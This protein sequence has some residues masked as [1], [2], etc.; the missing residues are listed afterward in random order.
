M[1]DKGKP[2]RNAS[3]PSPFTRT[4]HALRCVLSFILWPS[5]S[6][7]TL[8]PRLV[9]TGLTLYTLHNFSSPDGRITIDFAFRDDIL[10]VP[11]FRR[12]TLSMEGVHD[13][14]LKALPANSISYWIRRS[15][16]RA[17][18]D[19]PLQPYALRHEVGTELTDRGVSDQ[20]RNQILGHA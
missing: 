14:P 1:L 20:Q 17:G 15:G 4:I 18:F 5:P 10:K 12:S 6:P 7:T 16:Q 9:S 2:K 3:K 19:H 11:I 13:D 8:F